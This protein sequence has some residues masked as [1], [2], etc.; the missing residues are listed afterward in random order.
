[1]QVNFS[2]L[3]SEAPFYALY[4]P[5]VRPNR[6]QAGAFNVS[7]STVDQQHQRLRTSIV[8]A[9]LDLIPQQL[10]RNCCPR[11]GPLATLPREERAYLTLTV[12]ANSRRRNTYLSYTEVALP[13]PT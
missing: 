3:R 1:M 4:A 7:N 11:P 10:L 12:F 5:P 9:A 8:L 13:P 6:S 2:H